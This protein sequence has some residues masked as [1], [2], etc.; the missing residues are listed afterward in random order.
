[1]VLVNIQISAAAV[2]PTESND[3]RLWSF[4][5]LI[6]GWTPHQEHQEHQEHVEQPHTEG[7][8]E[9][10]WHRQMEAGADAISTESNDRR[11]WSFSG[12][13]G[14]WTHQEHQEH[15][16]HVEQPHTEGHVENYWH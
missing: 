6:G 15:Q 10:Y 16:E 7:H 14:G 2:A 9:N 8:V 1:M 5:G 11:L 3:R 4:S 12:L 13:I